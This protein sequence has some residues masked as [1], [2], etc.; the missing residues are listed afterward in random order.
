[1]EKFHSAIKADAQFLSNPIDLLLRSPSV[2]IEQLQ[3]YCGTSKSN[4]KTSTKIGIEAIQPNKSAVGKK[5]T[6]IL[7]LA[8]NREL[9]VLFALECQ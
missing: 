1:V 3:N 4:R 7:S 8:Q 9:S 2:V 5:R 6:R